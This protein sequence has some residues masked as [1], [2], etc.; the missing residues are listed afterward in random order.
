MTLA[1]TAVT[2]SCVGNGPALLTEP[3]ARH[4]QEPTSAAAP[5]SRE[6]LA[7]DV[8][9]PPALDCSRRGWRYLDPDPATLPTDYTDHGDYEFTSERTSEVADSPQQLCGQ[10]GPAVDLA[11][12]VSHGRDDVVIAVLDSG[13][14]WRSASD[15][16]S[17]ATKAFLNSAELPTPR[18]ADGTPG[19]YDLNGDGRFDV[20]DYSNDPRISDRNDNGVLDPEDLILTP[21]FNNGVDDD[22]NGYVDDISG[23]DF[24]FD[25]NNPLDNVEYG[26]GTGEAK[27]STALDGDGGSVGTCP[28][29]RFLPVRVGDSFITDGGRFAAGVAFSLDSG[30]DVIQEALG[31]LNNPS[32]VRKAIDSAWRRDVPIVASMADEAS[33]HPN[34]PA[35]LNHTIPVNSVTGALGQLQKLMPTDYLALNGCTNYG[36]VSWVAVPSSSCSSGAT[37]LGSG[38]VGLIES[39][40]RDA[41]VTPA[42]GDDG[43]GL[44]RLSANEVKQL[45]RG[46]ADDVDFST[47]RAPSDPPNAGGLFD[48]RYPTTPGWDMTFGFGR[49]NAFEAVRAVRAHEIPPEADLTSPTMLSVHDTRGVIAVTGSVAARRSSSYSYEV[50]WAPGAQPPPYPGSDEWHT[51][52]HEEQRTAPVEGELGSIDLAE[53]AAALPS[54]AR[55]CPSRTA[56]PTRTASRY[57][58]E[59]SSPTPRA[60][61]ASR[62]VRSSSTTIPTSE[63]TSTS[64]APVRRRRCS[65]TS[66]VS[67]ATRWCSPPTTARST[68][69]TPPAAT[70]PDGPATRDPRSTGMRTPRPCSPTVWSRPTQRSVSAHRWWRTSTPTVIQTSRSPTSTVT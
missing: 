67:R 40:A 42:S 3:L 21:A 23:W 5:S 55:V 25:D 34:L 24:L 49:V 39:A 50:Q 54:G 18:H 52:V 14:K 61:T 59:W 30:A 68:S 33:K 57:A 15:M 27:D 11:W 16:S 63:P 69:A 2:A 45:L 66:T 1:A 9:H 12:S 37:G 53:V 38:M 6:V 51:V 20:E 60:V 58:S 26:H 13:I 47:P 7:R 29:C 56:T 62:S 32:I 28:Q 36:A 41:D 19:P 48:S 46:T 10:R 35:V 22:H 17:L 4:G 43:P 8:D 65:P 44:N 31:V 64:R 70:C